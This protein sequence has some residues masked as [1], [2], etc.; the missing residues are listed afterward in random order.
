MTS[1][2]DSRRQRARAVAVVPLTS[3]PRL[4]GILWSRLATRLDSAV[5]RR[6]P[7]E[8]RWFR[9]GHR[10]SRRARAGSSPLYVWTCRAGANAGVGPSFDTHDRLIIIIMGACVCACVPHA[11]LAVASVDDRHSAK[12]RSMAV[13]GPRAGPL[14]R[15]GASMRRRP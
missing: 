1:Y 9:G 6:V 7:Q 2:F 13:D 12:K 3:I 15:V 14:A 11:Q 8:S 10:F 4:Q 5:D